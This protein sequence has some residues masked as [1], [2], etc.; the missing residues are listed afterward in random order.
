MTEIALRAR[1][2]VGSYAGLFGLLAIRFDTRWLRFTCIGLTVLGI[3][4]MA[5][6]VFWVAG[7]TTEA[8]PI[9]LTQVE[10]A[11]A[12]VSGYL[13][14]Y[15]L[16]FLTVAEPSVRDVAAYAL[17]LVIAGLIYVR[18]EM[19]QINPTLY[20]LLRRVLKVSMNAGW[21]GY[22]VARSS[23]K[24]DDVIDVVPLNERV[25]VEVRKGV[26]KT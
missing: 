3:G 15:L 8:E 23:L 11:G 10:D 2:F 17:F 12:D 1:L 22:V 21:S 26:Q 24:P 20:V 7:R 5:H 4:L 13:A 18:S 9:Q 25:R 14:T 16:P 6:I 19:T